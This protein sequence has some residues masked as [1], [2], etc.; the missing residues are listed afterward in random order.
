MDTWIKLNIYLILGSI[1]LT[2]L[3]CLMSSCTTS[4]NFVHSEGTTNDLI[5]GIQQTTPTVSPTLD[6]PI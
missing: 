3:F 4:I 1:L 5:D 2:L 6:V